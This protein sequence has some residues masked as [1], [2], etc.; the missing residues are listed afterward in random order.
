MRK[1][2][3]IE[4]KKYII[5]IL[6][7]LLLFLPHTIADI[8]AEKQEYKPY[9]TI[10]ESSINP[11]KVRPGDIMTVTITVID[12]FGIEKVQSKFFHE[13]GYD[14]IDL[15]LVSGNKFNGV[16]EGKW[17]V[18]D[19]IVKEYY[20]EVEVF[21]HSGL[22]SYTNLT[23]YDPVA[24]WNINW[25]YRKS[26]TFSS[27]QVPS[28]QTNIPIVIS[29]TDT[30]LRDNAKSNGY[31]IA[32][33][34]DSGNQLSHDIEQ[35][36]SNTG[37]LV[38]W[39]NITSL[40]SSTDTVIYI[41]YGNSD[42]SNQQNAAGVW[43]NHIMVYHLNE[44]TGTTGA[45][46]VKDSTGT[47][48]GTPSAGISFGQ[49]GKI[50]NAT[51]FS[52]G[53]G[54]SCGTL[55][56]S[57]LTA[58]TTISFWIYSNHVSSPS[59]QNPFNQAYG[60]W[61]TMTLENNGAISWFFGNNGGDGNTYGSHQS[62]ASTVTAGSWIYITAVRNPNGLSYSWY[63]NGDYLTGSTYS[64]TYPVIAD[65]TFTIGDGYVFPLN[66]KLDEFRVSSVAHSANWIK[67]QYNNVMNASDG[68]FYTLGVEEITIP[69]APTPSSPSNGGSTNDKTPTF[70]WTV[71]ENAENITFLLDD[72]SDLTNGDEWINISL[73]GLVS[74]Y[75]VN[76]SKN[77]TEGI[78][79]WKVVANNSQGSNSSSIYSFI[80][81]ITAPLQVN[82]SSPNN[83]TST[84]SSSVPFTWNPT[85]D[86][87]TNTSQVSDI[88][89]YNLQIDNDID[90]SSPLVNEN[91]DDNATFSLT[92]TVTGRLYWRVRAVDNAGNAGSF[93]DTR[94]LTVFS[95]SISSSETTL[96]IK[97]G[98]SGISTINVSLVFGDAENVTLSS[99]WSGDNTPSGI[100]VSFSTEEAPVSFDSVVTINCGGSA[101]T[102]SYTCIINGT[103]AS[104]INRS[105]S[106]EITVYSMLFSLDVFPRSISMIRSDTATATASVSFDQGALNTVILTGSW[107][108]TSPNGV[109]VS[110]N[111][112]QG[113]P[114]FDSTLTFLTSTGATAGSFV[115]RVTGTSAGLSKVANI[116]IDVSKNMTLT[117]LTDA[118]SYGKGESIQIYGTAKDPE[119]NNVASGTATIQLSTTN[120]LHSF[121][122]AITNG[123]YSTSYY[124]TFDKPDG[125]WSISATAT[126]TKGH[127]TSSAQTKTVSIA[128]PDTYEHYYVDVM[129]PTVGQLFKRGETVTFTISL[130]NQDGERMQGANVN[131][132]FSSGEKILLSE[133]S[134]GIYSN[135][136]DIGYDFEVGN[137]SLYVEAKKQ[138][139]G[140]LKVGFNYINFKVQAI[141]PSIEIIEPKAGQLMETGETFEIKIKATYPNNSPVEEG[142]I[143]A[144]GPGG[145]ELI[146]I[147]SNE[148]GVYVTSYT[149]NSGNIGKWAIQLSFQ[150]A[151]GNLVTTTGL[152]VDI[153]DSKITTLIVRY[154][155]ASLSTIIL[156]TCLI[157][158]VL[159]IN[160]RKV[161][162]KTTLNEI[163][164]IDKLKKKNAILYFSQG[165]ITRETY[166]RLAQE[167]ESKI[168]R[169]SKKQRML[170]KKIKKKNQNEK[171]GED[172]NIIS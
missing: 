53:T 121:T 50:G 76:Q 18:H 43:S 93:S 115:Y 69:T 163:F 149:P 45:G 151:Y 165:E 12:F 64:A 164:E 96:Q 55:G 99:Q 153:V 161:K 126:D 113:T 129:S 25:D 37:E 58:E 89:Y 27:G 127:V 167:Y 122:T 158:Y 46:S 104:G 42:A 29:I 142:V 13:Q 73:G 169:L 150:D 48:S 156:I 86:N 44:P 75:T 66:G 54:I 112:S 98:T 147:K 7:L 95:Y 63:K 67:T 90:F 160:L 47:T 131:A 92:K 116:Y 148:P 133:G 162:Y 59:R 33:T 74:S 19:T 154:W 28:D 81:D 168:A 1:K 49:T 143:L 166:D 2:L 105:V 21:S 34:D 103:S 60:G 110:Y 51:D 26:I 144:F 57:I 114:N 23:W 87:T 134:S 6:V 101:T 136:Y 82:L 140:K 77:L 107:I 68:G 62:S 24:W 124:V 152:E 120:W 139:D 39:V 20:T 145:E 137:L 4:T 56:S 16:W 11:T 141:N 9:P 84:D 85:T 97:K 65:H 102:G 70:Q 170:E 41:Y 30:S 71:G 94:T 3:I 72:E 15:S 31:D 36:N 38:A 106:I 118:D 135:S 14:L 83:D 132:Y 91:T 100:T 10:I 111:P 22:C 78:W 128:T 61:G 155:W 40:S 171:K 17:I 35:Y 79:Y 52:S 172:N 146:F 5:P 123:A 130:E 32:F 125:D 8:K 157:I 117:L 159:H 138:E 109:S 108:G 88:A 80:V 119:N